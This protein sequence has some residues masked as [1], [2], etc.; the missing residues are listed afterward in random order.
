MNFHSIYSFHRN[1]DTRW[2]THAIE[3]A[4]DDV[5]TLEFTIACIYYIV[6]IVV[7][8]ARRKRLFRELVLP[9]AHNYN[10]LGL[11]ERLVFA[12]ILA[13]L[14]GQSPDFPELA[15]KLRIVQVHRN[16]M[17][18]H[19]I[20]WPMLSLH[21]FSEVLYHLRIYLIRHFLQLTA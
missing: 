17:Y 11:Q 4:E 18:L 5:K 6:L 14:Q 20:S 13:N 19:S 16:S 9:I 1:A 12:F 10:L 15:N 3:I 8:Y 7:S 21:K 2:R